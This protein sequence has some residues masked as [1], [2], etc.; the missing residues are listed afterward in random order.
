MD[1]C[2][3]GPVPTISNSNLAGTVLTLVSQAHATNPLTFPPQTVSGTAV[4]SPASAPTPARVAELSLAEST[5][6][7][8]AFN[9]VAASS[10]SSAIAQTGSGSCSGS[11]SSCNES[12]VS[13]NAG[14]Y[15]STSVHST[16][17]VASS[18]ASDVQL[19]QQHQHAG[20]MGV[21]AESAVQRGQLSGPV[22]IGPSGIM[23]M[24]PIVNQL[25]GKPVG[26]SR[27]VAPVLKPLVGPVI[28][29]LVD[30]QTVG[31][32]QAGLVGADAETGMSMSE[33]FHEHGQVAP[34]NESF[35]KNERGKEEGQAGLVM[36]MVD[37]GG[38]IGSPI[39]F[40]GLGA[41]AVP[42]GSAQLQ[43]M[44]M[45]D[46]HLS[47]AGAGKETRM[48][49]SGA[50]MTG[51]QFA[52][53][54]GVINQQQLMQCSVPMQQ[55]QVPMSVPM[56]VPVQLPLVSSLDPFA[57]WAAAFGLGGQWLCNPADTLQQAAIIA[58]IAGS[59][60]GPGALLNSPTGEVTA[61]GSGPGAGPSV[62][63]SQGISQ[64]IGSAAGI[65][66]NV[67]AELTEAMRLMSLSQLA[68][69][70]LPVGLNLSLPQMLPSIFSPSVLPAGLPAV[71]PTSVL[72]G[73]LAG[74]L[75]GFF[76]AVLPGAPLPLPGAGIGI[77][78]TAA[79]VLSPPPILS[80]GLQGVVMRN[81]SKCFLFYFSSNN[82]YF[83]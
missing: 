13:V 40:E 15:M 66:A 83:K 73:V 82:S 39:K 1:I 54:P 42:Q 9:G 25:I 69:L 33:P 8:T 78:A 75:S 62:A 81:F 2:S 36:M 34:A 46:A 32:Q 38:L 74:P 49:S 79:P 70:Q 43:Y 58:G 14:S 19:Q 11:G 64:A 20:E 7:H 80:P 51:P 52:A 10:A 63:Q 60:I 4:S 5:A 22:G 50:P 67:L 55:M 23:T 61:Q 27:A 44:F 53:I 35:E 72:P 12:G 59:I 21:R 18:S 29:Q 17:S 31:E 30:L 24:C 41:N 76:P 45:G 47:V 6:T 16:G 68:Q 3:C 57:Q 65:G 56:P 28:G 48:V 26:V 37:D 71:L 77:P